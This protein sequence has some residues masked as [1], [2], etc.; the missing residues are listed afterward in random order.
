[1][2]TIK[3]ADGT[4]LKNLELNGN[5]FIA[6]TTIEDAVFKDNL[7]KVTFTDDDTQATATYKDMVLIQNT[8][9][10]DERSWF[11]LAE[12]DP[13]EKTVTDLQLALAEV[14]EMLLG[15]V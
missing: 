13:Q 2:Y 11:I 10:G 1:M 8:T 15:G 3:L 6:E 4:E 5:N 14:Y 7:S 12:R 9:Y